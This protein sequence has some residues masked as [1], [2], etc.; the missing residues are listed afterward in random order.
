MRLHFL[1]CFSLEVLK[2]K[3]LVAIFRFFFSVVEPF[4]FGPAPA[5]G[6][7]DGGSGSS[8]STVVYICCLKFFFF[9]IS[10]FNLPGLVLFKER[11]D[12]FALLFQYFF[13]NE[14]DY[15]NFILHYCYIISFL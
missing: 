4:H 6:S 11:Y 15:S 12:C 1:F 13:V 2:K 5:P 9:F 10:I 3:W 14:T 8:S 7:Q